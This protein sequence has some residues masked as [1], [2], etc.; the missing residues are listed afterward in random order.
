MRGRGKGGREKGER[1]GK[2]AERKEGKTGDGA[3]GRRE[4][5]EMGQREEEVGRR[6]EGNEGGKDRTGAHTNSTRFLV[7]IAFS[8]F[9]GPGVRWETTALRLSW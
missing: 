5:R 2:T 9:S 6:G 1:S 7:S 3:E 8:S 4:R